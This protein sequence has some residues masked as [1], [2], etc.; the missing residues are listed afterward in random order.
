MKTCLYNTYSNNVAGWC[1]L[2]H[3][4]MTVKQIK[5]KKNNQCYCCNNGR[6]GISAHDCSYY[7]V[8]FSKYFGWP[9][10][11]MSG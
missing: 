4:S 1:N 10:D 5:C 7:R 3:C 2:H 9:N 6:F 11:V 8:I